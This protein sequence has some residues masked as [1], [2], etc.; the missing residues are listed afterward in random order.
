MVCKFL[1]PV[2]GAE[3][4]DCATPPSDH[5]RLYPVKKNHHFSCIAPISPTGIGQVNNKPIVYKT[6]SAIYFH[7]SNCQILIRCNLYHFGGMNLHPQRRVAEGNDSLFL[8]ANAS[9]F[10]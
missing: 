3:R 6:H 9:T 2:P 10:L 1:P 8:P 7:R 4:C 5:G